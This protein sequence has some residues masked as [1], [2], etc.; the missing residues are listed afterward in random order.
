MEKQFDS[1]KDTLL[2]NLQSSDPPMALPATPKE[3]AVKDAGLEILK[4]PAHWPQVLTD[5]IK[6]SI[7]QI[8]PSQ[9]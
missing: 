1:D 7:L 5:K 3:I 9:F 6:I 2:G 4:D 8:G